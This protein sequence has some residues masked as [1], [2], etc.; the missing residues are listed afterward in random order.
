MFRTCSLLTLLLS[1]L[2]PTSQATLL[3]LRFQKP[4]ITL[5][6]T[7]NVAI[8]NQ[9]SISI[10]NPNNELSVYFTNPG[11]S[12]P[13]AELHHTLF[14]ASARVQNYLPQHADARVADDF[15]EVNTPFPETGD[16][17]SVFVYVYGHGLTWLQ[18][19][20]V[21]MILQQYMLGMGPG[22]PAGHHQQLDFYV[23]SAFG[24][25]VAHGAVGFV[26]GARAAAKRNPITTTLQLP[27]TN[28]SAP[29]ILA[30]PIIFNI[31]KTNLDLKITFLGPPIPESTV[32]D[33]IEEAYTDVILNHTDIDSPMPANRPYSYNATSGRWPRL[34]S[35][36][37][38]ISKYA[39]K[40]VS[41]GL[42]CI[43]IYG[44]RDFM[45]ETKHFNV[46]MFELDDG[47]EGRVLHGDVLYSPA[48]K[49][50]SI[51]ELKLE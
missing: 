30:L 3:P 17:V 29:S 10:S 6:E 48:A 31:P 35:T 24:N 9:T 36:E 32:L 27:Q 12:I 33:T 5:T 21:L 20:R 25:E 13:A 2:L 23:Q 19:S 44:L 43:L 49:P 50:P 7:T 46:M 38:L 40:R 15:F 26:P 14:V 28:F 8:A 37:I 45:R 47:K 51:G 11:A 41:W 42:V 22:H 1:S 16:S 18:L 39:G 34:S 4:P